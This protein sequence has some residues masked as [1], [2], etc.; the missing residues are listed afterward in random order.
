MDVKTKGLLHKPNGVKTDNAG[1]LM[2]I[3]PIDREKYS[4]NKAG[5]IYLHRF[6]ME[7]L[8]GRKLKTNEVVHHIDG[9]ALNNSLDNLKLMDRASH[10]RLHTTGRKMTKEQKR[11]MEA[12]HRYQGKPI[13]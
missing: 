9:D 2:V 7:V 12:T 11:L 3:L 4:V 5:S 6:I 1:Y 8:I 10:A 13:F